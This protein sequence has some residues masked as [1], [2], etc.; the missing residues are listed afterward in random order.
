MLDL[1]RSMAMHQEGANFF[2][3]AEVWKEVEAVLL[4]GLQDTSVEA[5]PMLAL[6]ALANFFHYKVHLQCPSPAHTHIA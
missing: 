2:A 1:V 6:R 4:E 3:R 5:N